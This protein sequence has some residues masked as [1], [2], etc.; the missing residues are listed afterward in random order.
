[1]TRDPFQ[2]LGVSQDAGDSDIK[3]AYRRLAREL[4][5]DRNPGDAAVEERFKE[6]GEAYE[7]IKDAPSREALRRG[8]SRG[9]PGHV[10]LDDMFDSIFSTGFGRRRREQQARPPIDARPPRGDVLLSIELQFEQAALGCSHALE[11][12]FGRLCQACEGRGVPSGVQPTQCGACGGRGRVTMRQ[13]GLF[14]VEVGCPACRGHGHYVEQ[15]CPD[16]R[17][18]KRAP[19]VECLTVRVPPGVDTGATIRVAGKGHEG[20]G[21]RGDL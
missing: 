6:L 19:A 1:V 10:G 17:G 21:G 5:P 8:N 11:V 9:G 18:E 16:C 3:A 2:V 15:A 14:V 4:H 12:K 20:E 7:L 13:G